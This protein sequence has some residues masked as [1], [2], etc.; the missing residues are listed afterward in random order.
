MLSE[1]P[2]GTRCLVCAD[3]RPFDLKTTTCPRCGGNVEVLLDH[4][5]LSGRLTPQSLRADPDGSMWRYGALLPLDPGLPRPPLS[6]GWTPLVPAPRLAREL[7]LERLL[8]KDE[9]RNPS[10]SLKDRASA[11][12]L[13]GARQ[14]GVDTVVGASTGN[15][16]SSM[17]CLAASVGLRCVIYVPATAPR[18]KLAQLAAFGAEVRAV[19]GSYDQAFDLSLEACRREG[20][21]SRS[22]G[23][24]PLTR[25]GKKTCALEIWEQLGYRV[26]DW[27][28]VSVGDG[29]IISGLHKGFCDLLSLG[30]IDRLPRLGA[31][32]SSGSN[33]VTRTLERLGT[34]APTPPDQIRIQPLRGASTRADSICVDLPRDGVAAVRA[35]QESRGIPIQVPD[36][37]ILEAVT[38]V[39][40]TTGVFGEPAG[41]ASVAGLARALQTHHIDPRETVVCVI[42]GNG[43]KD[44]DAVA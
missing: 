23:F 40:R 28:L 31:V 33:A 9:G 25:E 13:L 12:V 21:Y 35:V 7:G 34:E 5:Q 42:T 19:D 17:A 41:V 36:S 16:G 24:N 32:Q 15:A 6:I 18:A 10:G 4:G 29:N 38:L 27:V 1:H 37:R 20:W 14:A 8:L 26:P 44:V 39:A 11:T 22:T 2:R 30:L 3:E 43:L